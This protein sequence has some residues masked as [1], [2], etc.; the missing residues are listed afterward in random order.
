VADSDADAV[1]ISESPPLPKAKSPS[2]TVVKTPHSILPAP[3]NFLPILF[4]HARLLEHAMQVV[5][6]LNP[7]MAAQR[8]RLLCQSGEGFE[9]PEGAAVAIAAED[10]A[11]PPRG[12]A[13]AE[14]FVPDGAE[15]AAPVPGIDPTIVKRPVPAPTNIH[16]LRPNWLRLS[17]LTHG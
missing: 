15:K 11:A 5:E 13:V 1:L 3:L 12:V 16:K 8:R 14:P 7:A 2:G 9:D 10:K 4:R 17:G 6:A